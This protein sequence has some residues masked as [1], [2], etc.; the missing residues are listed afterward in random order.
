[1]SESGELNHEAQGA[2]KWLT[3]RLSLLI[4]KPNHMKT[5]DIF[6]NNIVNAEDETAAV[7]PR[8]SAGGKESLRMNAFKSA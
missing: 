4:R 2:R 1:M 8:E 3:N 6:H 5:I 7:N